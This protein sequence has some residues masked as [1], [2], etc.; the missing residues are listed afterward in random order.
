MSSKPLWQTLL[1]LAVA[2]QHILSCEECYTLM[3]QYTDLLRG[4]IASEEAMLLVKEHLDCC[5]GCEE[6]FEALAVMVEEA[7]SAEE[8]SQP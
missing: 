2:Q 3:D 5:H 6:M 8:T 1:E 7:E 4:G